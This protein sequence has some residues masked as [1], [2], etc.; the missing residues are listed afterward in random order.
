MQIIAQ[1]YYLSGDKAGCMK[2]I[3]N[4]FGASPGDTTLDTADALRL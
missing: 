2:Y 4:N 1:A 3:K